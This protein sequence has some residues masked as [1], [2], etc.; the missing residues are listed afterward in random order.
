M[1]ELELVFPTKDYETDAKEYFE[2]HI[3][4]GEN[5]LHGDSGLDS[6]ESFSTWLE[7]INDDLSCEI[8]SIIFFA[9]R[10]S[11]KKLIGTI[12]VRFPYKGYVQV[13]EHIG[14]GMRPSERRKGYAAVMLKLALEYCKEIGLDK[15][16]LTC[17]K[18][19]IASAKTIMKC[20]GV[21]ESEEKQ[22]NGELV[23]RYWIGLKV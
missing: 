21:F 17:S 6:A 3:L 16:L 19:N 12:N 7:K 14:Y 20:L 23:Q 11:D 5:S 4:N 8:R 1:D 9:I 22:N 10:K 18:S 2:E 15:V 13:H